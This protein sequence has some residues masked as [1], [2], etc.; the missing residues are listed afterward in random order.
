MPAWQPYLVLPSSELDN[1]RCSSGLYLQLCSR[2]IWPGRLSSL[3]RGKTCS[4]VRSQSG[5]GALW[6]ADLAAWGHACMLNSG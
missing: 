4:G 3:L 5:P 2:Q 6:L 1:A